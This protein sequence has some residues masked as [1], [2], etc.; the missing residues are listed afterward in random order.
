MR[1]SVIA[2]GGLKAGPERDLAEKYSARITWPISV[3]EVE[4][5]RGLKGA[6]LRKREGELILSSCP[7]GATIVALDERGKTM[8]SPDFAAR[9]GGWWDDGIAEIVFVIGGAGGLDDAVRKRADLVLAF[10]A[11]TLPHLLMR[12]V[13]LEQI[14]RAQTIL[15]G[16]PYHRE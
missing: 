1:I 6:A 3:R 15:A 4:D 13:L 12:G 7:D 16:H 9:L 14:Y 10:G 8:S 2:V 11:M 5:K